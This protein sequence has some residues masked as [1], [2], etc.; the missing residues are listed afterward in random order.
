MISISCEKENQLNY[1]EGLNENT[2]IKINS[3]VSTI[4]KKLKKEFNKLYNDFVSLNSPEISLNNSQSRII[5]SIEFQNFKT[6]IIGNGRL[7]YFLYIDKF[8]NNNRNGKTVFFTEI[9]FV[10]FKYIYEELKREYDNN[11]DLYA[12]EM[13]LKF[14]ELIVDEIY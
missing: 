2:K 13:S 7:T 10:E 5:S 14:V 4:D 6:F 12:N 3:V 1:S 8:V 9:F 11:P